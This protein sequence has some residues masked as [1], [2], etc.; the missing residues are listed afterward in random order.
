MSI[1]AGIIKTLP[2]LLANPAVKGRVGPVVKFLQQSGVDDAIINEVRTSAFDVATDLV[3]KGTGKAPNLA[4]ERVMAEYMEDL[5]HLPK[6]GEG[7]Q[8]T[9]PMLP[10]EINH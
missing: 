4:R 9:R 10:A 8:L 3:A 1:L 6:L 5:R 7:L 2:D